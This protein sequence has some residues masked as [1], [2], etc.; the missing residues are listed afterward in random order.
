MQSERQKLKLFKKKIA[1]K[2]ENVLVLIILECRK[3]GIL[4]GN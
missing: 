4:K 2:D 1:D 3:V